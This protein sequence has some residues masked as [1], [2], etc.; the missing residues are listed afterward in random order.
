MS[1]IG[2]RQINLF[3]T[4]FFVSLVLTLFDRVGILRPIRSVLQM[5]SVPLDF[6]LFRAGQTA[7]KEVMTIW[8]L[9]EIGKKYLA[10]QE[11]LSLARAEIARLSRVEGENQLLLSQ[12]G[13]KQTKDWDLIPANIIGCNRY[14]KIDQG[15]KAGVTSGMTVVYKDIFIGKV[16][17]VSPLGANVQLLS[18]PE[19]KIPAKVQERGS[20]GLLSGRYQKGAVL[21][22]ILPEGQLEKEDLVVT[23]GSET[24]PPDLLMGTIIG[25]E[26]SGSSPFQGAIVAPAIDVNLLEMVFVLKNES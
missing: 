22:K 15:E 7:K 24:I 11:A 9:R 26:K 18:D 20:K 4:L 12:I 19:F 16:I 2:T 5:A 14:L 8:E 13:V 1:K 21:E 23:V 10:A 25:V 3:L 17:E 6:S